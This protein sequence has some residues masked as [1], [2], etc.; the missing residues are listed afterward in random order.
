MDAILLC[1]ENIS[2]S[3]NYFYFHISLFFMISLMNRCF[4]FWKGQTYQFF[5]L[6]V[7]FSILKYLIK[8]QDFKNIPFSSISFTYFYIYIYLIQHELIFEYE[9][10]VTVHFTIHMAVLAGPIC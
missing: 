1:I 6:D 8:Y 4:R 10:W 5:L 9:V 3:L 2:P 7:S